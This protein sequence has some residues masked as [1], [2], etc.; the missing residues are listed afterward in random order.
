M[1]NVLNWFEIPATDIERAVKFYCEV[2]GYESMYQTNMEGL[3]M[4]FFP[5]DDESVGG[6]LCKGE[7]YKPTADGPIIYLN[8]NPDLA[9]PLSKIE[10]AG[11]H[12]VLPKKLVTEE[13][14]Y[15]AIF[16]DSEGNRV[17]FHSNK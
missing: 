8:A 10:A 4:A 15:M 7:W 5:M 6:S 13:I 1:A 16:I 14:G 11:G 2:M 9:I 12:V 3:D 17:A